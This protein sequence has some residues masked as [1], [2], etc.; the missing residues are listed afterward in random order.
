M[1]VCYCSSATDLGINPATET[2]LMWIAE[3]CRTAPL[4]R[5]WIELVAEEG[6]SYFHNADRGETTWHHPL[7]P[8]FKQLVAANRQKGVR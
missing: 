5:G 1:F 2:H 6:D 7:D 8:Y 3:H 4:P